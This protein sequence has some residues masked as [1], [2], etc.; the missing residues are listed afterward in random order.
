MANQVQRYTATIA[1]GTAIATPATVDMSFP[2]SAVDRITIRIPPGPLGQSGFNIGSSGQ[3]VIPYNAGAFIV[4]NDEVIDWP[5]E[6]LWDSGQW[7]FYGY[8]IGAY[9][10]TYEVR[11]YLT[12]IGFGEFTGATPP[13]TSLVGVTGG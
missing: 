9:P 4:G 2:P 13:A 7:T 5:L 3:Q 11:F 8:N 10:H 1:A 12:T 6:G